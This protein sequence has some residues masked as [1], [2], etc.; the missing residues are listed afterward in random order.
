MTLSDKG[1]FR[2]EVRRDALII[3]SHQKIRI[4]PLHKLISPKK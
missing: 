4:I 2:I 1:Q 3:K